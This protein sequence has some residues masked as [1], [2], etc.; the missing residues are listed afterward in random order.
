MSEFSI[1]QVVQLADGRYATVRYTEEVDFAEGQW[2]GV[3]MHDG[4]GKNDGSVRGRRYFDCDPGTGM[5]LKPNALTIIEQPPPPAPKPAVG[6]AKKVSRSSSVINTG[7][8]RRLSTV[9]DVGA[10]KRI[11]MNSGSPTPATRS[12]PSSMLRVS[13]GILYE[14]G[15]SF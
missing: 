14:Y 8:A 11:S 7:G 5:F 1:G 10:P 13:F 4:S 15:P 12:R 2:I 9:P 6:P 3:E